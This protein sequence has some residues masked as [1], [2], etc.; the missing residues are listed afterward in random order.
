MKANLLI[1]LFFLLITIVLGCGNEREK[2]DKVIKATEAS[3]DA[4]NTETASALARL[5]EEFA[6][7][8]KQDEKAPVYL[9]KASEL[10]VNMGNYNKSIELFDYFIERYPKHKRAP[11]ILF[12]KGFILEN[13]LNE[14]SLAKKTYEEFLEKYPN[15]PSAKS[16]RQNLPTIGKDVMPDWVKE[17]DRK[18]STL[19]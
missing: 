19:N 5:Y 11:D 16:V 1:A 4:E 15:H 14:I 10:Y 18:D 13:K 9:I 12:N 8:F 3:F 6:N 2:L 7:K 17:I